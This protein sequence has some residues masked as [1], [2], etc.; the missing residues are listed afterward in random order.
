MEVKLDEMENEVSPET[1]AKPPAAAVAQ[2]PPKP[3]RWSSPLFRGVVFTGGIILVAAI[4]LLYWYTSGRVS[5]DDAE[6]DGHLNP[7]AAKVSGNVLEVLVNDNQS[8]KAGQILVRIDP[9]DAQAHVD[10]ER[11]ALNL[12]QAQANAANVDVPMTAEMTQGG[13]SGASADLLAAFA[14][15]ASAKQTYEMATTSDLAYANANIAK[16]QATFDKAQSDVE[17]MK[18]LAAKAEI[19][20]QE[21]DG[22]VAK[23]REAQGDLDAAKQKLAQAQQNVAVT[24]AKLD[25]ATARVAQAQAGNVQAHAN[26][27]QVNVQAANAAAAVAAVQK[28]RANLAAAQLELDYTT[29]VAPVDGVVTHKSVEVGQ[30]VA[31]GQGLLIVIPLADVWVT[32]DFKETQLEKMHP[33]QKAEVHVDTYGL[34]F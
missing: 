8:V 32:A 6:V 30:I 31:P 18:P 26:L 14:D 2:T 27:K 25:S 4:A 22:Y 13:A 29:V 11:A 9:R 5:T 7:V 24:K 10:Q 1:Q 15:Q 21:F 12:A 28:A 19:S 17:R 16:Q 23:S 3:G 33:G 34:T 20:Q